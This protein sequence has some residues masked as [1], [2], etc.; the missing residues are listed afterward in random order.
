MFAVA[1]VAL[2]FVVPAYAAADT[3]K[4]LI[5]TADA[6]GYRDAKILNLH[7]IS[8]NAEFYGAGRLIR[9]ADGKLKKHFGVSEVAEEIKRQGGKTVLVLVTLE[10]LHELPESN[11]VE[12]KILGESGELT[13]VAVSETSSR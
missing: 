2:R 7:T 9:D 4:Y 12:S 6:N 13:I 3:T 8:H 1:A 10:Y 11:L 5:E